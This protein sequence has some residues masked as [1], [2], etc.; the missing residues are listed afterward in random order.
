MKLMLSEKK[1]SALKN[2]SLPGPIWFCAALIYNKILGQLSE[3]RHWQTF[4]D[5]EVKYFLD[6]CLYNTQQ[7]DHEFMHEEE[8]AIYL[9]CGMSADEGA[10]NKVINPISKA[11]QNIKADNKPRTSQNFHGTVGQVGGGDINNNFGDKEE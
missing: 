4:I 5:K 9:Q 11:S 1:Y 3:G 7:V 2:S 10:G 6:I 8:Q